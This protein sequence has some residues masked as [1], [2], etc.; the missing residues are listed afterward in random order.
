MNSFISIYNI[1]INF[2]LGT[3]SVIIYRFTFLLYRFALTG[4]GCLGCSYT[5]DKFGVIFLNCTSKLLHKRFNFMYVLDIKSLKQEIKQQYFNTRGK[6]HFIRVIIITQENPK[7][8]Y[9][10]S[11]LPSP[12]YINIHVL[13]LDFIS[14]VIAVRH[15]LRD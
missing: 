14:S 10:Y 6:Q 12:N 8:R 13:T 4:A 5:C 1:F 11:C 7:T 2:Q 9:G 3:E 15:Q